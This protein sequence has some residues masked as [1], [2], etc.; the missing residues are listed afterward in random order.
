MDNSLSS[1]LHCPIGVPQ[2]SNLGPLLFLIY[3]ND[4]AFS[5]PCEVDVYADD[6]TLTVSGNSVEEIGISLTEGCRVV[7]E[8]MQGN[9]LKLNAE[10][11]HI[12]TVGTSVRLRN[13][14]S[15]VNVKMDGVDLKENDHHS[16]KLLGVHIQ[17]DLKWHMQVNELLKKL[18]TRLHA[19]EKLRYSLPFSQKKIIVEGIFTSVLVY[20]LPVFAGCDQIELDSL[21]KMQNKAARLVTNLGI[22]TARCEIF[23]QIGWMTVRQLSFYYTALSTYRIRK[24]QEPEYLYRIMSRDNR[25]AK[26]IIPNTRLSLAKHSYCFRGSVQWNLLP[27]TVRSC[28]T[29]TSFKKLLKKWIHENVPQFANT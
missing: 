17:C 21:Q 27:E 24:H 26:I 11:T 3:Y 13:Q 15:V 20:C 6:S 28:Q 8:W 4:L 22:R 19:L 10:K 9:K 16:E 5:L 29:V 25:S 18:Q 12:M 14:D 1:F 7:N 2:G 23:R